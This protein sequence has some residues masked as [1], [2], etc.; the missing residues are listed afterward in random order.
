MDNEK[1]EPNQAEKNEDLKEELFLCVGTIHHEASFL[2]LTI[3]NYLGAVEYSIAHGKEKHDN[4]EK[5][6]MDYEKNLALELSKITTDDFIKRIKE[7]PMVN[8]DDLYIYKRA[9][10]GYVYVRDHLYQDIMTD[11]E[12]KDHMRGYLGKA[13]FI[14]SD[15]TLL[16][17]HMTDVM[18]R[19]SDAYKEFKKQSSSDN[20]QN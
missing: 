20:G 16:N 1:K 6:M 12:S 9:F 4:I 7:D 18:L 14:L 3:A 15:F 8:E 10:N 5:E 2:F 13:K 11:E 17:E 19:F